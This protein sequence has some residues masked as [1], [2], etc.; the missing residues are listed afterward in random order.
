MIEIK[1]PN[2][3]KQYQFTLPMV[4]LAGSIE[5]GQAEDWQSRVSRE[6]A[7]E[8]KLSKSTR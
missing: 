4:F 7:R 1:A 3:Y 8:T 5:M 2:S 6:S